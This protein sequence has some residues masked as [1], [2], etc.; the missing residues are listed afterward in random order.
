M[1]D[2]AF[3]AKLREGD[4]TTVDAKR[5]PAAL[6]FQHDLQERLRFFQQCKRRRLSRD[7]NFGGS[8]HYESVF[9]DATCL[10]YKSVLGRSTVQP[11]P[12]P[13]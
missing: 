1:Q 4:R 8:Q 9:E 5:V 7:D 3:V 11:N 10:H 13:Q 12:N 2:D 6:R